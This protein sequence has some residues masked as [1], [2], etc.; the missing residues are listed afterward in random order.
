M[1]RHA[2]IET[3]GVSGPS[4]LGLAP[5]VFIGTARGKRFWRGR[6]LVLGLLLL[7]AVLRLAAFGQVPPGLY[8]DEAQ[9]GMDA[10]SIL[11]GRPQLYFGANNGRE[12]LFVYLV[13]LGVAILGRSPLAVRLPSFYVGFLTLAATYDLGR[14]LWGRR[15]GR[16][17]LGVLAVTL[18]HV[19]LSRVG[20]RAVLLP[21]LTALFL[22]QAAKA[23]RQATAVRQTTAV[24][25]RQGNRPMAH[26]IVAGALYGV[27]WYTYNA[28]RFTPVAVACV[29]IYGLLTHRQEMKRLWRGAIWAALVALVV[30]L[31]LGL[32][33]LGHP[34][35]VLARTGQ[36]SVFSEQINGGHF[37]QTL[38]R[39]TLATLGM[40]TIR[41]DRIW[42]HNVSG[43]PVWGPA[44]GLAFTIGVGVALARFRRSA[45]MAT[46]L[47]WTAAMAVPTLLAEDAP[48]F[49]RGVGVLPTAALLPVL[50]LAWL[51]QAGPARGG[52]GLTHL[53]P[54]LILAAGL[55][56]TAH[57]YFIRYPSEPLAYHW[58]EAGPVDLAGEIN[59]LTGTGWDGSRML[60]S[61]SPPQPSP[62]AGGDGESIYVYVDRQIWDEWTSLPFLVPTSSVAFLPIEQTPVGYA[63]LA[64]V[65]WPYREWEPDVLPYLPHPAYLQVRQGPEAQG[66]LDP[67]PYSIATI[68]IARQRPDVPPP[69]AEFD[70]GVVLRAALVAPAPSPALSVRRRRARHLLGSR[71][72]PVVGDYRT[73][74]SRL[75]RICPLSTRRCQDRPA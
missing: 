11:D 39:H 43:R 33:T 65:V 37:W 34:D 18:W 17:A 3:L 47:L 56:S 46:V 1:N 58:F 20:F 4:R 72:L 10:L 60:H 73:S 40:F 62:T 7:G 42:R 12:P 22:S 21:L 57:D 55:G 6:L 36:V 26:W 32:Y 49:L 2:R 28:A 70:N 38:G 54:A 8:H 61:A 35:I 64:F 5:K 66:D 16:L 15:A 29:G 52:R 71:G 45:A 53:L 19:H 9:H 68:I 69:V 50:G 30:L 41:G 44:L 14:T 48:H 59:T 51:S 67:A 23:V 25:A 63:G 24:R 75:H 74:G 31:P 13:T 27:S